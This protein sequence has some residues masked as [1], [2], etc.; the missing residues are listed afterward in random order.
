L[1]ALGVLSMA[2]INLFGF[3]QAILN[4]ELYSAIL[5]IPLTYLALSSLIWG[6][7]G[8]PLVWGLWLGR[9]WAIRFTLFFVLAY[10]LYYWLD[11][12]LLSANAGGSNW[13]FA[14]ITNLILLL[15]IFWILY[16]PPAKAFFGEANDK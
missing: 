5:P 4:W 3:V 2:A 11:R 15:I 7:A 16:R 13:P 10:T 6:L 8:L 1:L 14:V 12:L 9:V